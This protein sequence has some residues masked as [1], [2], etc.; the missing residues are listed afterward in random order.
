MVTGFGEDVI[1]E[2]G[3][4]G[5][6]TV[7]IAGEIEEVGIAGEPPPAEAGDV[8]TQITAVLV[9]DTGGL[10]ESVAQ[11]I[12]EI[13]RIIAVERD[14]RDTVAGVETG[15]GDEGGGEEGGSVVLSYGDLSEQVK[16]SMVIARGGT[17]DGLVPAAEIM[18]VVVGIAV[19]ADGVRPEVL[20]GG[21]LELQLTMAEG[22]VRSEEMM[23]DRVI[24]APHGVE[25]RSVETRLFAPSET[26]S[27][28]CA[29]QTF[30]IDGGVVPQA[31][32]G[33]PCGN[34]VHGFAGV[35]DRSEDKALA[36]ARL[37]IARYEGVQVR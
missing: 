28:P 19:G 32:P 18:A 21:E 22:Q 6:Q 36:E 15:A 25:C 13:R 34:D 9:I 27:S 7:L 2:G 14:E 1:A 16:P 4:V 33:L 23:P 17:E 20:D 37:E 5:A 35:K 10:G 3:G 11:G 12:V 31:F 29:V 8:K 24:G 26:E 30:A